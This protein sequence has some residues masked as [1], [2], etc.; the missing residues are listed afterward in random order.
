VTTRETFKDL[1]PGVE[2][3]LEARPGKVDKGSGQR[4]PYMFN[5]TTLPSGLIPCGNPLCRGG[6]YNLFLEVSM[7]L[8]KNEGVVDDFVVTCHGSESMGR[9]QSRSCLN[10][11]QIHMEA[12]RAHSAE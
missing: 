9:G 2:L 3:R 4:G 8:K 1:H 7:R 10:Y 11:L 6:S 12:I 5:E